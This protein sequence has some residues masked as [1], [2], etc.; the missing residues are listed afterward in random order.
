MDNS[1][2]FSVGRNYSIQQLLPEDAD[3]LQVLYDRCTD[4]FL[5]S[6]GLAPSPTAA[7]E[8]FETPPDG[9][10]PQDLYV[11]GLFDRDNILVGVI[12]SVRHYPDDRTWWIGLMAI[13]PEYRG[14]GLGKD[15]YT[16]FEGWVSAQG[17]SQISLA[18]FATNEMGLRFWQRMGFEIDRK[19]P[20]QQFGIK[21]HER[22]ILRR[23]V[24][25]PPYSGRT[26]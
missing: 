8:E 15:F 5:F 20:P 13:A 9:K 4:F 22:Y 19:T 1:A 23:R 3:V 14:K 18:V 7:R 2:Q 21:T 12:E 17:I 10:T 26:S 11:F 24:P 25:L 6:D 16:A